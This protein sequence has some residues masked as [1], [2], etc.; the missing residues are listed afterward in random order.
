MGS[1]SLLMISQEGTQKWGRT[2]SSLAPS[3]VVLENHISCEDEQS[4]TES[5]DASREEGWAMS[6]SDDS[7][8]A[9]RNAEGGEDLEEDPGEE[10]EAMI[11]QADRPFASESYGTTAEE[12]K[13]GDPLDQRLGEERPSRPPLDLQLAIEDFDASDEEKDMVGR[14]SFEHDRFVAPEEAAMTVRDQAPGAVD[15]PD[16]DGGEPDGESS[17]EA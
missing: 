14:A 13:K 11:E 8:P 2:G 1:T 4:G 9:D 5:E 15:H 10:L 17:E 6:A 3:L 12:Q 7:H 16:S